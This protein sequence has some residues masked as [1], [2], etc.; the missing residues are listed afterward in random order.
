MMRSFFQIEEQAAS[1]ENQY[2][3]SLAA[4]KRVR[5]LKAG[6]PPLIEG[7][8]PDKPVETALEELARGFIV[9]DL[10]AEQGTLEA[11]VDG[12]TE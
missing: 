12:G 11:R 8:K 3:L 7:A 2:L 1:S 10:P 9:Y 5:H 6:S 4:S